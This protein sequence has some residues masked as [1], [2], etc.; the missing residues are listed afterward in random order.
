MQL[1]PDC[2]LLRLFTLAHEIDMSGPI[3]E[4][5]EERLWE[6]SG[7]SSQ[8]LKINFVHVRFIFVFPHV[9]YSANQLNTVAIFQS[10]P[11]TT[12]TRE[13]NFNL[14]P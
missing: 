5:R 13:E 12:S 3:G 8:T 11:D 6:D 14:E 1:K 9:H 4:R 7:S 2:G 10:H